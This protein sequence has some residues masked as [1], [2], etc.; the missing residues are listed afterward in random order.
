MKHAL[1]VLM[2]IATSCAIS[3][4]QNKIVI[5]NKSFAIL[6]NATKFGF[7]GKLGQSF[8]DTDEAYQEIISSK[9]P[10]KIFIHLF[11]KGNTSGKLYALC[12]LYKLDRNIFNELSNKMNKKETVYTQFGCDVD[13]M[14]VETIFLDM[15]ENNL[16]YNP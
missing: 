13:E 4:K 16:K 14:L 11:E 8:R 1:L 7:G 5:E 6:A 15:A 9:K 2:I 10:K 3:S 12:G